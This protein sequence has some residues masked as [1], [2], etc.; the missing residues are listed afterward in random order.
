M[1]SP[2][3]C[4]FGTPKIRG[5]VQDFLKAEEGFGKKRSSDP[6]TRII[7]TDDQRLV[8]VAI[9][10]TSQSKQKNDKRN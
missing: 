2:I 4:N 8:Y 9:L 7:S 3:P 5:L 1:I 6:C 10:K